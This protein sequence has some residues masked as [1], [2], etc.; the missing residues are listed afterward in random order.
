MRSHDSTRPPVAAP[1]HQWRW[2][3]GSVPPKWNLRSAPCEP[4][5]PFPRGGSC[6]RF[7]LEFWR[8]SM[9]NLQ[10]GENGS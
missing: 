5:W 1:R 2:A 8:E 7:G 9:G 6:P 3:A 10:S 4:P